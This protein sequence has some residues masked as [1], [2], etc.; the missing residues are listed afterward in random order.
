MAALAYT[1]ENAN[2]DE[3][4]LHVEWCIHIGPIIVVLGLFVGC[5]TA[6]KSSKAQYQHI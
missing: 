5:F 6:M 4:R 3:P 2:R 1:V